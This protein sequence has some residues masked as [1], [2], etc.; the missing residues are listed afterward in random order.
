MQRHWYPLDKT[1]RAD[2]NVLGG[3]G[4]NLVALIAAGFPVPPGLVLT[5]ALFAQCHPH[6]QLNPDTRAPLRSMLQEALAG[7]A[8]DTPFAV[9]SSGADEDS[10]EHSFAGQHDTLLNVQGIEALTDAVLT[11]WASLRN[12]TASAYRQ[13]QGAAATGQMAVV[14]QQMV[15][16]RCAG[17]MF[18]RHPV[19]PDIDR[20]VIESVAGLGEALV[21]GTCMPDRVEL[22]R[23]GRVLSKHLHSAD[24]QHSLDLLQDVDFV[25]LSERLE[26]AFGGRPQDIEWA[27]DGSTFY[28]LQARPITTLKNP[29]QVWTRIWGDEFWAEATTPLQYTC[30]G[31][32]IREDYFYAV[33]RLTGIESLVP[34]EPFTRIH[35]HI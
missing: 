13:Q 11:C 25:S 9:R 8:P 34:D 29:Q 30:L 5:T 7:F 4:A 26:A 22:D 27:F 17:V 19:R 35:S 15:A 23:C 14:I 16:A 10:G 1:T 18:T 2:P 21:S 12:A 3:K 28:L 24:G 31:R 6:G 32:W 33:R 20:I